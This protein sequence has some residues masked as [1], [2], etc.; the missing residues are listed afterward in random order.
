METEAGSK[1]VHSEAFNKSPVNHAVSYSS[2]HC[3]SQALPHAR[4]CARRRDKAVRK[5]GKISI[6]KTCSV[7]SGELES[8]RALEMQH[9]VLGEGALWGRLGEASGRRNV[10]RRC[11]RPLTSQIKAI[12]EWA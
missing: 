6:E 7:N 9:G 12:R 11:L 1:D 3:I 5:A 2:I 4:L 10:A 8:A